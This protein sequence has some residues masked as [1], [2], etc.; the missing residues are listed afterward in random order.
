MRQRGIVIRKEDRE[1]AV[2]IQDPSEV[3]GSCGGCVSLSS[4]RSAKDHVVKILDQ[5]DEY[6][7]G[8]EVIVEAE[9]KPLIKA[10]A[11]LYSVPFVFLFLGYALTNRVLKSDPLAGLGAVVGLLI[12]GLLARI[13]ARRFAAGAQELKIV[14]KACS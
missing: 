10:V 8:D 5:K 4:P 2:K 6:A 12:G 9:F 13:V 3:C 1:V 7:V 11:V 14:A